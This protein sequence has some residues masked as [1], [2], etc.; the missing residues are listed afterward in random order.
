MAVSV[1]DQF[2]LDKARFDRTGAF[3]SILDMDTRLFIDPFLLPHTSATELKGGRVKILDRFSKILTLMEHTSSAGDATWREASRLL[4]FREAKG[5]NFGYGGE[6]AAGSGMGPTIRRQLLK[7]AHE[8]VSKGIKDPVIFELVGI[9]EEG[10]GCDRISDMAC[11]I[12]VIRVG[13]LIGILYQESTR[14]PT[15]FP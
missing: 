13:R 3:D 14:P 1:T 2:K 12:I 5:F 11:R 10:I 15:V 8:I 4:D 7:T 6:G 9:F